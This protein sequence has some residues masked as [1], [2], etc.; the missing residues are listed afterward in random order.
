MIFLGKSSRD[1][2]PNGMRPPYIR[3]GG[4][5]GGGTRDIEHLVYIV[6]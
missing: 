5:G 3:V 2:R 4:G 6:F 1:K